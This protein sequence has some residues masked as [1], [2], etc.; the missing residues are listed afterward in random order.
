MLVYPPDDN[1][2][3][4]LL[5]ITSIH[6][7]LCSRGITASLPS[8]PIIAVVALSTIPPFAS[9]GKDNSPI[10]PTLTPGK[11]LIK[12]IAPLIRLIPLFI[13]LSIIDKTPFSP[14]FTAP[15]IASDKLEPR[16]EN[17]LLIVSHKP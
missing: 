12:P 13:V 3:A 7:V 4:N 15:P 10:V 6:F 14:L 16:F 11:A 5:A 9:R 17:V 1:F 2:K 8:S